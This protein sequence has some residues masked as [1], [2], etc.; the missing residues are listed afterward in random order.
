MSPDFKIVGLQGLT[1]GVDD[2]D[3]AVRFLQDWNLRALTVG[4]DSASYETEEGARIT[5]RRFDDPALPRA[6]G[7]KSTLRELL[8]AVE[9]E[10]E[11]AKIRAELEKDRGVSV[12]DEVIRVTEENGYTLGFTVSQLRQLPATNGD[13]NF[14]GAP[15][16]V[17]RAVDFTAPPTVRHL[18]HVAI[19]APNFEEAL[20]FYTTRLGFRVSDIYPGRGVFL[21]A[22]G[23]HDHHNLFLVSRG[24][25]IGFHHMSFEV[26]DFHQVMNGGRLMEKN[27]WKTQFGPGRH[28]LGSNYFWY[29][30]TPFGGAS[31]YYSDM[32]Y[33][34]DNWEARSWEYSPDIIAAW[35]AQVEK[36]S[37]H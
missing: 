33:L 21:R 37:S 24:D 25:M 29:F 10:E 22:A 8:W 32:D 1:F 6:A 13:V 28:T 30:H 4:S 35:T 27:G 2:F 26:S 19:F 17:N 15:V 14:P 16:R 36:T 12:E 3:A 7:G 23:S 11:L 18:G 34:D 31:E 5:I 20:N 9:S